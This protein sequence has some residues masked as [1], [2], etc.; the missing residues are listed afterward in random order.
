MKKIFCFLVVLQG[1]VLCSGAD[2]PVAVQIPEIDLPLKNEPAETTVTFPAVPA[3]KGFIPV[4]KGRFYYKYPRP[5]GWN[6]N[7]QLFL[8]GKELKN[9]LP[10]GARRLLYRGET[11]RTA[12]GRR[13]WYA[14]GGWLFYFCDGKNTSKRILEPKDE[15]CWYCFDVSD[16]IRTGEN[17]TLTL[18][19]TNLQKKFKLPITLM[20]R[21]PEV[22]YLSEHVVRRAAK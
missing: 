17:N 21:D 8:N 6:N 22:I 3:R 5:E 18:K 16:L 20:L 14:F 4:L 19:T 13:G 10:N 15:K 1:I 12:K 9:V 2:L 7:A 11:L